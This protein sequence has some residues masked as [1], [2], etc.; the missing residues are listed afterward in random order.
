MIPKIIHYVWLG[1]KPLPKLTEACIKSWEKYCPGFEIK[2]WD[3][4]N[5]NLNKYQ[6]VKDALEKKKYAFAS[7]VLR[8][9][10]L[11]ENGG[12]YLDVDVELIK[13]ID[14][15][16]EKYKFVCGFETSNLI[17]PGLF[18]ATE[19][20]NEDLLNILKIYEQTKFDE[21]NLMGLTVCEIYTQYYEKQGLK[22]ENRTQKVLNNIFY[23]SQFFSPIDVITNKKK[24]TQ[25]TH[26]IHWYN[27]SWYT[28]K[29]KMKNKIKKVLNFISFGVF[30]KLYKRNKTK[31]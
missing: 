28:P 4:T 25:Q 24:I 11:Y 30:G 8:T 9:E 17:N 6:F 2:R 15:L 29:Q 3:E 18:V 21:T 19:K 22:R 7:D 27:A 5:L 16:L 26:S 23:D 31:K 13:P 12:V 10:V 14:E 1:G 20:N